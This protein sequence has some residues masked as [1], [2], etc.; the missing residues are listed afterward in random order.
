MVI[1]G[2]FKVG[3]SSG[4]L[5]VNIFFGVEIFSGGLRNFRVGVEKFLGG[6]LRNFCGGGG[7]EKFSEWDVEK[8]Q[9]S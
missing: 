1:K 8:V 5:I 7:F 4:G 3:G 6:K 9:G 2:A